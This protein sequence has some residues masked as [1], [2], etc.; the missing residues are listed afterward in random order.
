MGDQLVTGQHRQ[1]Q[2]VLRSQFIE[3]AAAHL[4]QVD[5]PDLIAATNAEGAAWHRPGE[6][7]IEGTAVVVHIEPIT[8]IVAT[9]IHG[10]GLTAD[11]PQQGERDE[12]FRIVIGAVVV[13]AV[14]HQ[15]RQSIGVMPG[16]RQMV[17]RRLAGGVGGAGCIGAGLAEGWIPGLQAAVNLVGAHL[18]ETPVV[19]AASTLP[20]GQERLQEGERAEH[21]RAQECSRT[22][23]RAVHMALGR[24]MRHRGDLLLREQAIQHGPVSDVPFHK[25]DPA[26][27]DQGLDRGPMTRVR[28]RVEHNHP[29]VGMGGA[30]VMGEVATDEAGSTGDQNVA[31]HD[32]GA[33]AAIAA[34]QSRRSWRQT[35]W[36][37]PSSSRAVR[38]SS[39]ELAGRRA[40]DGKSAV[41]IGITAGTWRIS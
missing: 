24:Q 16:Q 32:G 22:A 38:Q 26:G 1:G 37:S 23:D 20:V 39:R 10:Y 2:A 28:E 17:A 30:P 31:A 41:V 13:G 25:Q 40:G 12:L 33:A 14:A 34:R 27:L 21:I 7:Q 4:H 11:D 18:Q 35:G 3:Q 8:H 29:V 15:H 9:S 5:V 19:W 36:L 6:N